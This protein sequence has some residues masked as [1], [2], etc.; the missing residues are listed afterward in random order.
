MKGSLYGSSTIDGIN[1]FPLIPA[2]I[3]FYQSGTSAM[4]GTWSAP[5]MLCYLGE[6]QDIDYKPTMTTTQHSAR[7]IIL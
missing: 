6:H 2:L 5:C 1:T 4:Y 7:N 3:S